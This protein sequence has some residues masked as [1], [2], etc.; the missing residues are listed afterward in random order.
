MQ[1]KAFLPYNMDIE[2]IKL[3]AG[4]SWFLTMSFP[5]NLGSVETG[6][7]A[8][9]KYEVPWRKSLEI[10]KVL[11]WLLSVKVASDIISIPFWR[12]L[13]SV[14]SAQSQSSTY[15]NTL[16]AISDAAVAAAGLRLQRALR[17]NQEAEMGSHTSDSHC[18]CSASPW[19][20]HILC[21][22]RNRR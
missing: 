15:V 20:L 4:A 16:I 17:R 5:A 1:S 3:R 14:Q 6:L 8:S 10:L 22:S 13:P 21:S 11:K 19:L 9:L 12:V 2:I 18:Y 7:T